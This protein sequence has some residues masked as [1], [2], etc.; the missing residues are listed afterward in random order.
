MVGQ[1]RDA[2]RLDKAFAH[3][4][5]A[6]PAH[7]AD[8]RNLACEGGNGLERCRI[9]RGVVIVAKPDLE[10]VAE[11]VQ[12]RDLGSRLRQKPG[13]QVEFFR[14]F[15]RQM[16]VGDEQGAHET[17]ASVNEVWGKMLRQSRSLCARRRHRRQRL[18]ARPN[19]LTALGRIH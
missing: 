9:R 15:R 16:Q 4:K 6:I 11:D 18:A 10:Q 17:V 8:R 7:H 1:Q 14:A 13:E 3:Q 5:V 19:C 2:G 12:V